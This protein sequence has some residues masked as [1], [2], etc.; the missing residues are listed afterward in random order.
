MQ[1]QSFRFFVPTVVHFGWNA[2]ADTGRVV[3][4]WGTRCLI[5]TTSRIYHQT[6]L[7]REIQ[8]Q[9]RGYH[10]ASEVFDGIIPNPTVDVLEQGVA[11]ARTFQPDVILGVGGGSSMDAA[12]AVA[13]GATHAGS[14]WDYRL[15]G[16]KAI[17]H[18]VIPVITVGTTAGT[19]SQI[20]PVS[21]LTHS[22][23]H[24][25][26]AIVDVKLCP[27]AAI[28]DP[29]LTVTVPPRVTAATGFDVFAHA[30][31]STIHSRRSPFTDALAREALT[32]VVR[33]L[34][35]AVMNGNDREAREAMARADTLAGIC[36][37]NAG[38]TLPHGIAMAIG[39]HAPH[40]MH[41]EALASVY[42]EVMKFS[43]ASAP[44]AFARL[45]DIMADPDESSGLT[46]EAKA[47]KVS[48]EIESFLTKIGLRCTLKTLGVEAGSLPGIIEDTFHLPDYQANPKQ[49]TVEDVNR[50][51]YASF[52]G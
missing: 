25:K 14:V 48:G 27:K 10:V 41:G 22:G 4:E 3:R 19:G 15:G 16:E 38:T 12:K 51:V 37:T 35:R 18:P 39:G 36:I 46:V 13:L 42:P 50:L 49:P 17:D 21:V 52:R 9:L 43:W 33:Y 1:Q 44:Q 31:E 45:Y 2:V 24:S 40:V 6:P 32:L 5:V 11:V 29:A 30:F 7:I 23:I 26:H 8:E 20:S 47:Q 34:P 28:V